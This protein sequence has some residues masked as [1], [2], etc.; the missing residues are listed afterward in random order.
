MIE[1]TGVVKAERQAR[2]Q[3]EIDRLERVG[4]PVAAAQ[5]RGRSEPLCS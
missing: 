2:C 1:R 5:R 4:K 3:G